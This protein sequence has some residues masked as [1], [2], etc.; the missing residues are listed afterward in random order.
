[1]TT[2]LL[3]A[4]ERFTTHAVDPDA[5][6]EIIDGVEVELAEMSMEA[7]DIAGD[8]AHEMN[9]IAR[10]KKLGKVHSEMMFR[11]SLEGEVERSRRP[12]LMYVSFDK[13]PAN[14]P[15]VREGTWRIVPDI[16]VEVVS[17][18]DGIIE[19]E[20]KLAEYFAVGVLQVWV[21]LPQRSQVKVYRS[22]DD[23]KLLRRT[24]TLTAEGILPGF[25]LPLAKLFES[26]AIAV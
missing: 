2:A 6:T 22:L 7:V 17:P 3:E 12:D 8:L 11:L 24:D 9:L 13:W 14:R 20:D 26:N 5:L 18:G 25:S 10:A 21:V 15:R 23:V 16:C 4:P 19:L 1:M